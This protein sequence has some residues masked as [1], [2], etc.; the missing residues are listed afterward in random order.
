[1]VRQPV[2]RYCGAENPA[3]FRCWLCG[4]AAPLGRGAL[5]IAEPAPAT[6]PRAAPTFGLSALMLTVAGMA[7]LFGVFRLSAGLG[8]ALLILL[9]PALVRA[10]RFETGTPRA[11]LAVFMSSLGVTVLVVLAA[12]GA[13]FVVCLSVVATR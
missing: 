12:F 1:M 6:K 13:F 7:V 10:S 8:L 11:K 9:T 3:A 4:A 2:C 5:A